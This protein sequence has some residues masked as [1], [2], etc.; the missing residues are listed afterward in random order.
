DSGKK[1]KLKQFNQPSPARE[2]SLIYHKSEL[3]IQITEALR[4]VISG[5]VRGAIRFQDVK[6]ISPLA[7]N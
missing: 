7:Y 6:I 4:E 1:E 2:I 5:I 3:K